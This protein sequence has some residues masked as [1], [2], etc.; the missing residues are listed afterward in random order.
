[1][2]SIPPLAMGWAGWVRG[3]P[4]SIPGPGRSLEDRMASTADVYN[5]RYFSGS[6]ILKLNK[7]P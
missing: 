4:G 7:K 1:M 3:D 5:S 6:I 2:E